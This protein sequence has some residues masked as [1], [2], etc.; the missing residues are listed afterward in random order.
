VERGRLLT[1]YGCFYRTVRSGRDDH[2]HLDASSRSCIYAR[3]K[4]PC[5]RNYPM[6]KEIRGREQSMAVAQ[7]RSRASVGSELLCTLHDKAY[8]KI[9]QSHIRQ[10]KGG[11]WTSW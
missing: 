8:G 9:K 11:N 3:E 1:D 2:V 10:E 7:N 5:G 4:C 6:W